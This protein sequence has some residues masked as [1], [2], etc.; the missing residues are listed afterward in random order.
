MEEEDSRHLSSGLGRLHALVLRV[1]HGVLVAQDLNSQG[2]I[3][4]KP[5]KAFLSGFRKTRARRVARWQAGTNSS[6]LREGETRG[7]V[8]GKL[9]LI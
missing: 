1:G 5:K 8:R 2:G 4:S 6:E 9:G 7:N 3:L